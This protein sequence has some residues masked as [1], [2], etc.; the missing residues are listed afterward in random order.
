MM[1]QGVLL[2]VLLVVGVSAQ[3]PFNWPAMQARV[4]KISTMPDDMC[5]L[6]NLLI[7]ESYQ[8]LF[9]E[10][11][12]VACFRLVD[13]GFGHEITVDSSHIRVSAHSKSRSPLRI[14]SM[15]AK[16]SIRVRL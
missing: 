15:L 14:C 8:V 16:I 9:G 13:A 2:L 12:S 1:S 5:P 4:E 7:T 10:S 6:R 11:A 3:V